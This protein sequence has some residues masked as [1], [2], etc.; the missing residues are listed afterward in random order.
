M[1]PHL[2]SHTDMFTSIKLPF[3]SKHPILATGS[4]LKSSFAILL[5]SNVFIS[6][7]FDDL[8]RPLIFEDFKKAIL[9]KKKEFG[10]DFKIIACDLHPEY[11][12]TKYAKQ[13]LEKEKSLRRKI[14]ILE[15]QHHHAHV[16]AC[17]AE[18]GL[19]RKVIGVAF[20]GTG[21]GPDGGVWGGEFLVADYRGFERAAH[22]EY[23]PM[24]GADKAV[25][26]PARMAFSY[27]YGTYKRNIGTLKTDVLKRIGKNRY[28][29][30]AQMIDGNINS[31]LTSSAGR[32]FDAVSSLIGIKDSISYEGEAAIELER[33]AAPD[34]SDIYDFEIKKDKGKIII[35]FSPMIKAIVADLKNKKPLDLIS[36]KFHNALAEAIKRVCVMLRK[37][38]KLNEVVL[39]GGVFQNRILS[40]ETL[41]RL[42]NAHFLVYTHSGTSCADRS[43]SLGQAVIAAHKAGSKRCA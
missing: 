5:G 10:R 12:S 19:R 26:E 33:I 43:L 11:I 37:K 39:S 17:M 21:Y 35:T 7:V 27:L 4:E 20:D 40:R 42:E 1:A 25:L 32:L 14:H 3:F 9:N 22:L 41:R 28:S 38:T 34:C 2:L 30:F 15:I 29:L 23:V 36:R 13:L 8:R 31:P 6:K 16:T 18:H 24:P